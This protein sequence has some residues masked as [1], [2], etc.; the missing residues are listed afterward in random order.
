MDSYIKE[1][2]QNKAS[3]IHQSLTELFPKICTEKWLRDIT[4]RFELSWDTDTLQLAFLDPIHQYVQNK[5]VYNYSLGSILFMEASSID[6]EKYLSLITISEVFDSCLKLF[7]DIAIYNPEKETL[8]E[9]LNIDKA[10]LANVG[11]ALLTLPYY[12]ILYNF[13]RLSEEE[14]LKFF[15]HSSQYISR[16]QY[17]NGTNLFRKAK[18][19]HYKDEREYLQN[20]Y[21]LNGPKLQF[22]LDVCF[23]LTYQNHTSEIKA[24]FDQLVR[25]FSQS[26]QLKSDYHDFKIWL[27]EHV[28]DRAE[29]IEA[30]S[31]IPF[32]LSAHAGID[33][34][35]E[36]TLTRDRIKALYEKS[37]VDIFVARV[38]E[39]NNDL[40]GQL[41]ERLPFAPDYR[42]IIMCYLSL[43]L[44]SKN[45][46]E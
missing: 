14:R 16:V 45:Q 4:G 1:Y 15:Q 32:Y 34:L 28:N 38:L 10:I 27:K 40:M 24:G 36:K 3:L 33:N 46:A 20:A 8:T 41:I 23:F 37:D 43:L 12:P 44:D 25:I 11:V 18:M 17:A 13:P 9:G 39:K 29:F 6:P 21:Y 5:L 31:F 22:N 35:F 7:R 26:Y 2:Y 19:L 30:T 42:M